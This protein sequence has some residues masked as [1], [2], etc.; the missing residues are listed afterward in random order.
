MKAVAKVL[1]MI[2][3]LEAKIHEII[4]VLYTVSIYHIVTVAPSGLGLGSSGPSCANRIE[5]VVS[6]LSRRKTNVRVKSMGFQLSNLIAIYCIPRQRCKT[7]GFANKDN[8]CVIRGRYEKSITV[9]LDQR[10]V[11]KNLIIER[12]F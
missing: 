11:D 3:N 4:V 12:N 8:I 10:T 7:S 5:S 2:N 9:S 1:E 6:F